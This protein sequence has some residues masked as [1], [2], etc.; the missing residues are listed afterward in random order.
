M[1]S[2]VE[3]EIYINDGILVGGQKGGVGLQHNLFPLKKSRKL[4]FERF[5]NKNFTLFRC[6]KQPNFC[7]FL[8]PQQI[9]VTPVW[10]PLQPN[11]TKCWRPREQLF[12]YKRQ[13]RRH[14]N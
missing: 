6:P 14:K 11:F 5:Q 12:K 3:V 9:N 7:N 2:D 1:A 10:Y 13:F 8:R 4:K